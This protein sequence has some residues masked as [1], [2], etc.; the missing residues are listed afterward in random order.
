MDLRVDYQATI[1]T[2]KQVS[3][4]AEEFLSNLRVIND[5]NS[6]LDTAWQGQ[7]A[8]KYTTAVEQQ[9]KVMKDLADTISEMGMFLGSVG[10]TYRN[11]AETNAANI[12]F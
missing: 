7:D 9:A 3:L 12:K 8:S 1:D 2:G 4:K 6:K 11:V 5:A 10:N